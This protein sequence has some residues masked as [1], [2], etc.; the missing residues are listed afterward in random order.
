MEK[1]KKHKGGHE[2]RNEEQRTSAEL[3]RARVSS[4]KRRDGMEWNG[5]RWNLVDA[6]HESCDS[7]AI[8]IQFP[9]K[10]VSELALVGSRVAT[11]VSPA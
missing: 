3:I 5:M 11:F 2:G 1:G 8:V 7:F 6:H 4:G 9:F 10:R